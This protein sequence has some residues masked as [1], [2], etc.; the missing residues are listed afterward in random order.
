MMLADLLDQG[1]VGAGRHPRP[2]RGPP[3]AAAALPPLPGPRRDGRRQAV[4]L[5]R[6]PHLADFRRFLELRATPPKHA[7]QTCRRAEPPST[8][9]MP[10]SMADVSPS[11]RGRLARRGAAR[12]AA[13]RI[14]TSNYY[15]RDL[16]SFCR[17][18]VKDRRT[19][20]NPLAHLSGMNAAVERSPR[21]PAPGTR[22][23]RRLRRGRPAR[24]G[25][26]PAARPRPRHALHPGR[27]H[28]AARVGAGEPHPRVLRPRRRPAR[29]HR[30]GRA[31][32]SAGV[33]TRILLRPDLA[34][35]LRGWLAD[36]PA[37]EPLWPGAWWRTARRC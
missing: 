22:R 23:L 27:L 6:R 4:R 17:W 7:R 35:L 13:C 30:G 37:G 15:L 28:R 19:G 33:K 29:G 11:G 3:Q 12:P 36:R 5:P 16:K 18:L 21:A 24:A 9:A 34:A 10:S 26:P 2:V 32:A 1:R 31:T 20:D 25:P 14:Q 8:A